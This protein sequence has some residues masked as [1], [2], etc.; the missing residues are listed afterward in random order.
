MKLKIVAILFITVTF[1]SCKSKG[2]IAQ[3]TQVQNEVGRIFNK[4][5]QTQ[6][7]KNAIGVKLLNL[8]NF[9]KIDVAFLIK[10]K[11]KNKM[12]T[13]LGKQIQS[14][15]LNKKGVGKYFKA[16]FELEEFM[17]ILFDKLDKAKSIKQDNFYFDLRNS[18]ESNDNRIQFI[19][20]K[21]NTFVTK[22]K[23]YLNYPKS[24]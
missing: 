3:Q 1:S 22:N 11:T 2:F 23:T 10:I 14:A 7:R 15:G 24:N 13:Q 19:L 18:Y 6:E 8:A 12:L 5:I 21:Y 4:L 17:H 16:Q 9:I 20:E